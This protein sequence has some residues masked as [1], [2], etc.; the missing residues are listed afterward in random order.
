MNTK[1]KA[2][3]VR[4]FLLKYDKDEAIHL[5]ISTKMLL[6]GKLS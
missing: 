5:S 3:F 1:Q 2:R 4:A 6:S